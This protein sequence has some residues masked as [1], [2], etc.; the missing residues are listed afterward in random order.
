MIVS[1]YATLVAVQAPRYN[2][3]PVTIVA[4]SR[5]ERIDAPRDLI[6]IGRHRSWTPRAA[7]VHPHR[8][9]GRHRDHRG[10]DR[11]AAAR[12]PGG[13]RGG[14]A[15][16]VHQQPEA[17][18]P[19]PAQL[20]VDQRRVPAGPDQHLRRRQRPLLGGLLA[21]APA[22]G[23][24]RPLFNAMNFSMNPD[25]D[26]TTTTRRREHDR[27]RDGREHAALPV[28]RR[29]RRSVAVGGGPVRGAQLPAERRLGLLGGPEP[30]RRR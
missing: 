15:D 24:C 18:R 27:G 4:G 22:V 11:P 5:H 29:A 3:D 19:G 17:D 26:Y 13:A 30:A 10:A 23:A 20:R 16:P 9:A 28:R 6:P 7:G 2:G 14:P 1:A 12:R 25:P 8:A 21:D